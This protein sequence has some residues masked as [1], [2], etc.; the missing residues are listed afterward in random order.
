MMQRKSFWQKIRKHQ[1]RILRELAAK[2]E[3]IQ[4]I[5]IRDPGILRG[6]KVMHRAIAGMGTVRRMPVPAAEITVTVPAAARAKTA[7]K[8]TIAVKAEAQMERAPGT[9]PV[10]TGMEAEVESGMEMVPAQEAAVEPDPPIP[11]MIMS[12]SPIR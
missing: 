2:M 1:R 10:E 4:E 9:E 12:A 11:G 5:R 3:K 7:V 6:M 8:I